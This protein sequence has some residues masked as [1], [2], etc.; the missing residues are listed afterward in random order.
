MAKKYI[1]CEINKVFEAKG[2][3]F[4]LSLKPLEENHDIENSNSY[5]SQYNN[6][7]INYFLN[8]EDTPN[9]AKEGNKIKFCYSVNNGWININQDDGVTLDDDISL[10]D[11][12]DD[13]D[14][15]FDP[16]QFEKETETKPS[17]PTINKINNMAELYAKIFKAIHTH[18]YLSKL[19]TGLKKDIATSFFIEYNKR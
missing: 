16:S 7:T 1:S 15:S 11:I 8:G 6:F 10:E 3:K 14:D 2:G 18:E 5:K 4:G 19:D 13:L 9:W 17:D 12:A